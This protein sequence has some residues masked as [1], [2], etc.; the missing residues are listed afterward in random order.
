MPANEPKAVCPDCGTAELT[1]GRTVCQSCS[2][3]A[4]YAAHDHQYPAYPSEPSPR[5][6]QPCALCGNAPSGRGGVL[7]PRCLTLLQ[8]G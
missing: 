6:G 3:T 5:A 8:A 7:C 2:A 4:L 1:H